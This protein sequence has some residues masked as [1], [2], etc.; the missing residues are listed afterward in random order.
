VNEYPLTE[1]EKAGL[2]PEAKRLM[3]VRRQKQADFEVWRAAGYPE[4]DKR[5]EGLYPEGKY[6]VE[7]LDG[8]GGRGEKHEHCQYFVLDVTHDSYSRDALLAYADACESEYPL[9]A[10]DLRTWA[11]P[12]DDSS[13]L[14]QEGAPE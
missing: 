3:E 2:E 12:G 13:S 6:Y 14:S 7:R 1:D 5:T 9:L 4:P 11:K 10:D 8:R